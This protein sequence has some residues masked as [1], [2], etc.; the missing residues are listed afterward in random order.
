MS[1]QLDASALLQVLQGLR[2]E[3]TRHPL[4]G[5]VVYQD[6]EGGS[7]TYRLEMWVD[8]RTA[9]CLRSDDG[10]LVEYA[11][12]ERTLRHVGGLDQ[13]DSTQDDADFPS[14]FIPLC[15]AAP[16][17][18][19]IWGDEPGAER[20]LAVRKLGSEVVE[21]D[22]STPDD[23]SDLEYAGTAVINTRLMCATSFTRLGGTER[24]TFLDPHRLVM[25]SWNSLL[26]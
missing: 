6:A 22:Y 11:P 14:R 15:M 23:G 8:G 12:M 10:F 16:L 5:T 24:Y 19:P 18:L 9:R 26:D 20:T 25:P 13:A 17:S 1:G 4:T 21:V 3:R 2:R 7:T